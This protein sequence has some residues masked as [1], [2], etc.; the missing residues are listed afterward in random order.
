MRTNILKI[1]RGSDTRVIEGTESTWV[2]FLTCCRT[3]GNILV[4]K[5]SNKHFSSKFQILI[6]KGM[7]LS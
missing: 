7:A 1:V 6:K 2:S 3:G 4:F 5:N